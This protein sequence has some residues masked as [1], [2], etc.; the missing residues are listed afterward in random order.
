[1]I[2]ALSVLSGVPAEQ[3]DVLFQS[4]DAF[5]LM[6]LCKSVD[7]TWNTA[8]AVLAARPQAEKPPDF[9][10]GQFKQLSV[11]SAQKLVHFW[12]GRQKVSRK[13]QASPK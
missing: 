4:P 12:L 5:G 10:H 9:L 3:I 1:M 11:Q 2:A 8:Y 6:V 7:L 13:F